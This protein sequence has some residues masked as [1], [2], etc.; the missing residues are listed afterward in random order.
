MQVHSLT[1]HYEYGAIGGGEA[2]ERSDNN[3]NK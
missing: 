2:G 1:T 3:N